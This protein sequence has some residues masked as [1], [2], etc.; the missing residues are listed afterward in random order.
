M[1]VLSE[2]NVESVSGT[3]LGFYLDDLSHHKATNSLNDIPSVQWVAG[4]PS[5]SEIST[6]L[7]YNSSTGRFE[8]LRKFQVTSSTSVSCIYF[9]KFKSDRLMWS[10]KFN[11]DDDTN[12]AIDSGYPSDNF[13]N[14]VEVPIRVYNSLRDFVTGKSIYYSDYFKTLDELTYITPYIL[15]Q[16]TFDVSLYSEIDILKQ[17]P[18]K[19]IC[20]KME[21]EN[22]FEYPSSSGNI[23]YTQNGNFVDLRSGNRISISYNEFTEDLSVGKFIL[24]NRSVDTLNT[25]YRNPDLAQVLSIRGDGS[26]LSDITLIFGKP[27]A[28]LVDQ[29]TLYGNAINP[30]LVD[31]YKI[32]Q[33][34]IDIRIGLIRIGNF[35]EFPNA[36][37]GL[38]KQYK[39][40]S[41]RTEL[42]NG[43]HQYINRNTAKL[44]SGS[45]V[46]DRDQVARLKR[47]SESQRA[48]PFAMD[49]LTSIDLEAPTSLFCVFESLPEENYSYRTG[50]VRDVSFTVKQI[51]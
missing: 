3:D 22:F 47:F 11:W 18:E 49:I 5:P 10:A 25:E 1:K 51:N 48:K 35:E 9:G 33:V 12:S 17:T 40:Y 2:N 39:D 41:V 27:S 16:A 13:T 23:Y 38:S 46:L 19:E 4:F 7:S 8:V 15:S 37:V 42:I 29:N 21:S 31:A 14:L 50:E 44:Y 6:A 20:W 45:L 26:E 36:Q 30:S 32:Q 28:D 34:L 43:G 24:I